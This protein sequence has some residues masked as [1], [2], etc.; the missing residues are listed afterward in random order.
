ADLSARVGES[1][2]LAILVSSGP[3]AEIQYTARAVSP[4]IMGVD[5]RVGTRLPA[6]ATS[7]GRVLLSDTADHALLDEDWEDGL[8][9]IAVPLHD[10]TGHVLAAVNV[11]LHAAGRTEAECVEDLLPQLRRTATRIEEELRAAAHFTRIP[12]L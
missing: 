12:L 10:R 3:T 7:L 8:R 4:R 2:A 11:A 1:T 6:A 5:I 9:T